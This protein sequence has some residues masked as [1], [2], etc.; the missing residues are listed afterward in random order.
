MPAT[1]DILTLLTRSTQP[2]PCRQVLPLEELQRLIQDE[3]DRSDR[4]EIPFSLVLLRSE[5]RSETETSEVTAAIFRRLRRTDALGEVDRSCLAILLP[6]TEADAACQVA[7]ELREIGQTIL[8]GLVVEVYTYPWDHEIHGQT[9]DERYER[10]ERRDKPDAGRRPRVGSARPT[11][12]AV[13]SVER[14]S[15]SNLIQAEELCFS[16]ALPV[17]KRTLDVL[18]ALVLLV[19]LAPFLLVAAIAIKTTSKGPLFFCQWREGKNGRKFR[20]YKF[21]T[22]VENAECLQEELRHLSE[23]NGPAFKIENDPR[24]TWVGRFLRRTCFDEVPQLINVLQGDMT[25][26][27][28]RPLPV[29]ESRACTRWQRRRLDVTPGMTCIWQVSQCRDFEDWM[30]MDLEYIE[31]AGF[32]LDMRLLLQTAKFVLLRRASV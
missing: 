29:N 32:W 8:N 24:L 12:G 9:L 18:V 7:S 10:L 31:R 1:D 28:P 13:V 22:M 25:L 11:S 2:A 16:V 26:V 30:R 6:D 19:L 15:S 20:I 23:Q 3:R 5:P 4:R 14:S 21:R 27:G 17:W